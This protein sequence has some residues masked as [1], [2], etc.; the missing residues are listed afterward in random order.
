LTEAKVGGRFYG[1]KISNGLAITHL[2]FVDDI[3]IF[4]DGSKRDA[5]ILKEGLTLFK[6]AMSMIII[7][8][9]ITPGRNQ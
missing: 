6:L 5:D 9:R 3:L 7:I 4:C 8:G 2:L 1:I